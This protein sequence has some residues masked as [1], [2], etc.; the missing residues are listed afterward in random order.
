MDK[1][2]TVVLFRTD[3]RKNRQ[4][5]ECEVVAVF[6]HLSEGPGLVTCYAHTGQHGSCAR[7]WY[8]AYTRPATQAEYRPLARELRNRGYN[9]DI[10][11]RWTR[12]GV[13]Q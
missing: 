5:T 3:K 1:H 10:R 7:L 13:A 4:G 8:T 6:P 2:K 9:L 12:K 11:K